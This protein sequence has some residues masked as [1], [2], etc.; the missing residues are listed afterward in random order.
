MKN[1]TLRIF[2]PKHYNWMN[3]RREQRRYTA[4][5]ISNLV[6]PDSRRIVR[7]FESAM[8]KIYNAMHRAR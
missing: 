7:Q 3:D 2:F 6:D 1:N 4:T 5:L 8:W